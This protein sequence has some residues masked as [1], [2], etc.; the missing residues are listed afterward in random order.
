[1]AWNDVASNQMVSYFDAST[2][3]IPLLSGQSHF[4]TLPAANQCM[5]KANMQAKYSLNASNLSAYASNQLVPKS[6]WVAG[7]TSYNTLALNGYYNSSPDACSA[8]PVDPHYAVWTSVTPAVVGTRIYLNST[9][10]TVGTGY[11]LGFYHRSDTGQIIT[12]NSNGYIATIHTCGAAYGS[13]MTVGGTSTINGYRNDGVGTYGSMYTTNIAAPAGA[14]AVLH[15]LYW[16]NGTLVVQ[17][18]NGS[19]TVRPDGWTSL[20]INGNTVSGGG[21]FFNKTSFTAAPYN[22]PTATWLWTLS[23]ATNPFG[24]IAGVQR[25]IVIQ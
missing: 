2:S 6:A 3:G 4:T 18:R 7:I 20:Y 1:M 5:T 19:T 22:G 16:T 17:M 24:S 9:L 10:T 21:I 11:S 14:N 8:G 13:L 23:V 12:A 25:T 15:G